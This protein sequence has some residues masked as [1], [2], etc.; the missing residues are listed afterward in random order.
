M[1]ILC[2]HNLRLLFPIFLQECLAFLLPFRWLRPLLEEYQ[3]LSNRKS[4][5][6]QYFFCGNTPINNSPFPIDSI[7]QGQF[8]DSQD[9]VDTYSLQVKVRIW[10]SCNPNRFIIA[11]ETVPLRSISD[12]AVGMRKQFLTV[13]IWWA[14][15]KGW[16]ANW[17]KYCLVIDSI[18]GWPRSF[19]F[20]SNWML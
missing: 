3:I 14:S 17:Y 9:S 15:T 11:S 12:A 13:P 5:F 19:L 8:C 7:N 4:Y 10:I 20:C 1:Q 6:S 18:P 16:Y 2:P